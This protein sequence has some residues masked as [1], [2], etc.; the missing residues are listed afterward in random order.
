MHFQSRFRKSEFSKTTK[1]DPF[2][3]VM[4]FHEDSV[5]Y[6]DIWVASEDFKTLP[7]K[8]LEKITA[9]NVFM[10]DMPEDCKYHSSFNFFKSSDSNRSC[11]RQVIE[12]L[13]M[14]I[15]LYPTRYTVTEITMP[16]REDLVCVFRRRRYENCGPPP[17]RLPEGW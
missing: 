10:P 6:S 14:I 17:A 8:D 11:L 16:A 1:M 7:D 15:Q 12:Y 13:N 5:L 4:Y 3:E 9:V 2:V